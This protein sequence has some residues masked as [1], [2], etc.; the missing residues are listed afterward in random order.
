MNVGDTTSIE[1]AKRIRSGVN[2]FEKQFSSGVYTAIFCDM[3]N[4]LP[5]L[6]VQANYFYIFSIRS[7]T[8]SGS[9]PIAGVYP[10]FD[11]YRAENSNW[12]DILCPTFSNP[13]FIRT[14]WYRE[15]TYRPHLAGNLEDLEP[16]SWQFP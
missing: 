10:G 13:F 14:T 15:I 2:V 8:I 3:F 11:T 16:Y 7:H 12:V 5:G 9:S 4:M 6:V 1:A